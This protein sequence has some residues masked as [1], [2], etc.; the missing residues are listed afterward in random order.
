MPLTMLW[1]TMRFITRIP[2]PEKW[3]DGVEFEH[4]GRGVPYFPIVGCVVG[5]IAAFISLAVS[6]TGGG[7]Y[8]GALAYV[9]ALAFLTSGFHLDGLADTCDGLFSARSRDRMLEIM[10]DSRLGTHGG[11]ALIFCILIKTFAVI[12]LSHAPAN[13]LFYLLICAPVA[14]RAAMVLAMYRQRYARSGEGMGNVY[15]GQISGFQTAVTLI[16]GAVIVGLL[17]GSRGLITIL[18]SYIVVYGVAAFF[19]RQ[20]NG[21]TG[22]TLGALEEVGEMVFLLALLWI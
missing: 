7:I 17:A 11:L 15:I 19:R 16:F 10:R 20:L 1:A 3:A 5:A 13:E 6:Q 21:Q 18:V 8:I 9:L 2:V 4:F 22:D 12:A 14:G